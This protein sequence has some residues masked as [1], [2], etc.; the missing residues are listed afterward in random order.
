M[1]KLVANLRRIGTLRFSREFGAARTCCVTPNAPQNRNRKGAAIALYNHGTI[2][3]RRSSFPALSLL[4]MF[5][6][7][8]TAHAQFLRGV[9]VAGAEFGMSRLPG[10]YNTDYTYNSEATF[11]YF[12]A[13]NLNLIRLPLQWER[14]QPVLRGPL[15]PQ[16]LALLK[17]VVA[18]VKASG[19]R[20]ILDIHNFARYSMNE[21]GRLNAYVID[22][23]YGGTMRVSR[24]DLADL[25]IRLS[26]EFAN[27]PAVYAYDLM[28]E[29]HDMSGWKEISQAVL[30]AI[31]AR[32]DNKLI[33][34]PG[35]SWSSANRWVSVHGPSGWIADPADN[36]M[37]EAH[38]Y[39]D[40]DES[41]TYTRSY[42]V[43]LRANP[44]LATVGSTRVAR[45][46]DW[47]RDNRARCFLGE[48]GVPDS[49][50]RWWS[51]LD[52]FLKT[53]DAA[54]I[55][56]TYWAAGEWWGNYALGVQPLNGFTVDRPQ[57]PYLLAHLPPGAFTSVSAASNAGGSFAPASLM[58]GY[59]AGLA[60]ATAVELTDSTGVVH[61]A[62]LL[63]VSPGQ[64]N[65]LIPAEAALGR[66]NVAVK[67]PEGIL[68]R[69]TFFLER[70]A[71]TLFAPALIVRVKS[72]GSQIYEYAA[73]NA[74]DFGDPADRLFLVLYGTG[75][76]S[77]QRSSLRVGAATL[78]VS[79]LGPQPEFPGLDQINAEL[80]RSLA[81][82]VAISLQV[83][84][85]PANP[86]T[87][88]FR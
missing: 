11:R 55:S 62:P 13:R 41:G 57:M 2:S 61:Q 56:G 53:L 18:W 33:L 82:Q 21:N 4:A 81:G 79:Y 29:P 72:G 16:N 47:C 66:V 52:D 49:D 51:V 46:I 70:V 58:S 19:G 3:M 45:F 43:E 26:A 8:S 38:Q 65:Y 84:S 54:G 44:S 24:N 22:Q 76:R 60:P 74:V 80:P 6:A 59:G 28:N 15:D 14:L 88:I 71:P 37:Y 87:L 48:Y 39:F 75:F 73:A 64:I 32:G 5:L 10:V 34:V 77:G 25:W 30:T 83:D 1:P 40:F 42:D 35:D 68:G 69:G 7:A 78:S 9:N 12:A 50:P 63:F 27:E 86:V 85:K 20:L 67:S 31:R 17:S 23:V 36:F